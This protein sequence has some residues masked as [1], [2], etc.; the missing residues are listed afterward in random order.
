MRRLWGR[1]VLVFIYDKGTQRFYF[2]DSVPALAFY[3]N[4]AGSVLK[5]QYD[6]DYIRNSVIE[7]GAITFELEGHIF[8]GIMNRDQ[9][10]SNIQVAQINPD[11]R[12]VLTNKVQGQQNLG[13]FRILSASIK[14]KKESSAR[15]QFLMCDIVGSPDAMPQ[16]WLDNG[17]PGNWLA[18]DENGNSL[19]PDGSSKNFKLSRKCLECYQVLQTDDNGAQWLNVTQYHKA[20]NEGS[21][22]GVTTGMTS[23]R[24]WMVF[25]RAATNPFEPELVNQLIVSIGDVYATHN[26]DKRFGTILSTS[27]IGKVCTAST[28]NYANYVPLNNYSHY[29]TNGYQIL[30][31]FSS[32]FSHDDLKLFSS[33]NSPAIKMFPVLVKHSSD[34][35]YMGCVYKEIKHDN[36]V[37]GDDSTFRY[38]LSAVIGTETDLNG[39][40][41]VRGQKRCQLPYHF[42]ERDKY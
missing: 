23:S 28:G 38:T 26:H 12:D 34:T 1:R 7:G 24:V 11:P 3:F 14:Y 8:E 9:I 33:I 35:L 19:I 30:N 17:I 39:N 27:L 37:I 13:Q 6:E 15:P 10:S 18:T 32:P 31:R 41:V 42:K 2:Y 22:N 20:Y 40:T 5:D 16:E 29:Q 21:D 4:A 25:Y 36:N